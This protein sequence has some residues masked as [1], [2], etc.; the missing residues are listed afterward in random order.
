MDYRIITPVATE[1]VTLAEAKAH[2]RANSDTFT[3]D[4]TT[5]QS[6]TPGLHAAASYTGAAV[7]VLGYI[8]MAVLNAG[9][10]GTSGTI[11]AKMQESD[12]QITWTDVTAGAF[13][14][15]TEANDNAVQELAYTGIK[16]YIRVYAAVANAPCSF[17]AD[18]VTKTG[19]AIEDDQI[20]EWITTAREYCEGVTRRALAT[21]TI[22]AYLDCFPC[23]DRFELPRPPLQSVTS[24]KYKNS[25]GVET[26]MTV[27]TDYI[28]DDE[29]DVGGIVRPYGINWPSFTPYPLH[30]IKI[31][32]VAGYTALNPA[33]KVVKQAM[34]LLIGHWYEHREPLFTGSISKEVEFAVSALLALNKAGWF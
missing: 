10:C 14:T 29:S 11:S 26:T 12:D 1:P 17:G 27:D 5:T 24:V 19:D 33:P 9:A 4:V 31:R 34:L 6:I 16:Q 21:Q 7:D 32:Y 23:K 15:V 25:D 2:I 30:P 22:E 28:V 3:G 13:T 18:I 8:A 20:S